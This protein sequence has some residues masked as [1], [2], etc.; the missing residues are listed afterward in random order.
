MCMYVCMCI[1]IY[2]YIYIYVS[3]H[4]SI[5]TYGPLCCRG[6]RP[7]MALQPRT[8]VF[9]VSDIRYCTLAPTGIGAV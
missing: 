3:T 7:P 2:I 1:H 8:N 9:Q 5:D 4:I 6:A